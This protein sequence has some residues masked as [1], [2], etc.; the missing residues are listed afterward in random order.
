MSGPG[1]WKDPE[2]EGAEDLLRAMK[3][4]FSTDGIEPNTA[5][6]PDDVIRSLGGTPEDFPELEGYPGLR[7]VQKE[8]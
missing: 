1:E 5:I 6:M 7:V 4:I 2:G 8:R 3:E